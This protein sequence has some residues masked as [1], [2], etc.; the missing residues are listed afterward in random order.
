MRAG[1]IILIDQRQESGVRTPTRRGSDRIKGQHRLAGTYD[2]IAGSDTFDKFRL[3]S[4]L[5]GPLVH[6]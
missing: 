2:P 3:K 1:N 5:Y 4:V 6:I